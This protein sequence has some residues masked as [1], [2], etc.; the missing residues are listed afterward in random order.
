MQARDIQSRLAPPDQVSVIVP[1]VDETCVLRNTV[2]TLLDENPFDILEIIVV[3]PEARVTPE[4]RRTIA[5]VRDERGDRIVVLTQR[6][7]HYGGA[8]RDGLD[9]ARGAYVSFCDSDGETDPHL[10]QGFIAEIKKGE[11]DIISASRWLG[12]GGFRGY[13]LVK[14]GL[15]HCFQHLFSRLYPGA[16]TD[17]TYGYRIYPRSLLQSIV[18]RDRRHS[19]AL[20]T[21]LKPLRLGYTVLE[22]P[23]IWRAREEGRSSSSL[24]ILVE[25]LRTALAI[26]V[27]RPESFLRS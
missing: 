13:P 24:P 3:I 16:L 26:R 21:L 20:E 23:T 12:D 6:R 11:Y 2:S 15:N 18:W 9:R 19:F 1:A 22:I 14:L 7:P 10:M 17:L 4:C 8:L 5:S 27:A 25:Y